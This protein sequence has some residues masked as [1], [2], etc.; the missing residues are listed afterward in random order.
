MKNAYLNKLRTTK[1]KAYTDGVWEGIQL[2]LNIV[3]IALNHV[4]G[5]GD[6]RLTRL[7]AYVQKLFNEMVDAGDPLV[8]KAHVE[9]A[10]RQI[11][12]AGWKDD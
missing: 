5:F 3:A 4:F 10:V 8:N 11:R 2:C 1:D 12:K 7:E 6:K 9:K